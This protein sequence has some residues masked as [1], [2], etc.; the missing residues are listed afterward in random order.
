MKELNQWVWMV[1]LVAFAGA[2]LLSRDITGSW[3]AT[4]QG[5]RMVFNISTA[6]GVGLDAV[7]YNAEGE[8]WLAF[9]LGHPT[10]FE[11]EDIDRRLPYW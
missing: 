10:G 6:D 7:L 9:Q 2:A 3:R 5:T 11:A 8:P 1:A 4:L